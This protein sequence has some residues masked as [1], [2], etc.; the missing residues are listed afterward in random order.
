MYLFLAI[1]F[2][3][4]IH[5]IIVGFYVF[6]SVLRF[7]SSPWM[8]FIRI[9]NIIEK[10]LTQT[11]NIGL[12]NLTLIPFII[13]PNYYIIIQMNKLK[14]SLYVHYFTVIRHGRREYFQNKSVDAFKDLDWILRSH[15]IERF[16]RSGRTTIIRTRIVASLLFK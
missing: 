10:I 7:K 16:D 13:M 9:I 4:F 6:L 14:I 2:S 8:D 12:E 1:Y 3:I 15:C 5:C 11:T